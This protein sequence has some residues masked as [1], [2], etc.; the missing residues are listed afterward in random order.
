MTR[1][2]LFMT[3]VSVASVGVVFFSINVAKDANNALLEYQEQVLILGPE[4]HPEC[5][6]TTT[7]SDL[8]AYV[9]TPDSLYGM[10]VKWAWVCGEKLED[11]TQ[12]GVVSGCIDPDRCA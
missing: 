10:M 9:Q 8:V 12:R 3:L 7:V 6:V 11:N 1:Y 4:D 5:Q 2:E